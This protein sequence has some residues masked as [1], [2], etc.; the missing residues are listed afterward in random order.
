ML[1]GRFK[2]REHDNFKDG[3]RKK[4]GGQQKRVWLKFPVSY[5]CYLMVALCEKS[6]RSKEKPC[7]A[8]DHQGL[9]AQG[10]R[11]GRNL[12]GLSRSGPAV[13]LTRKESWY[14]P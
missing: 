10:C 11:V 13:G 1:R 4:R 6:F 12:R 3:Q 7:H 9:I 5:L 8:N 2:A 14:F